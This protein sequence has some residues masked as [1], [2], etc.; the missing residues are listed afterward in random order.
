LQELPFSA[1]GTRGRDEIP[2]SLEGKTGLDGIYLPKQ[3]DDWPL[4]EVALLLI[5]LTHISFVKTGFDLLGR[6]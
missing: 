6:Y 5:G 2:L 3:L 4:V 1:S